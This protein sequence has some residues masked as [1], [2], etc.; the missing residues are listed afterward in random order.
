MQG[1]AKPVS[2]YATALGAQQAADSDSVAD[3]TEPLSN[4][5]PLRSTGTAEKILGRPCEVKGVVEYGRI[6]SNRFIKNNQEQAWEAM[7]S[8]HQK[9]YIL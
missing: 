6:W 7:V 1:I 5:S 2:V 9:D 8:K 3:F 4:S